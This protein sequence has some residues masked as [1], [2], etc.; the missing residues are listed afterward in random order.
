[1]NCK[2]NDCKFG[3]DNLGRMCYFDDTQWFDTEVMGSTG[4][5]LPLPT[6]IISKIT[7]RPRHK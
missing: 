6:G 4:L 2:F 3:L 1:L 7:H 5:P